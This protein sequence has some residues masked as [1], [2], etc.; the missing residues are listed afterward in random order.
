MRKSR[1]EAEKGKKWMVILLVHSYH[2]EFSR[3]F[4]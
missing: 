3:Q 4:E 1:L 2:L